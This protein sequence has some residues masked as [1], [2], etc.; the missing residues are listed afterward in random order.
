V[1]DN[2]DTSEELEKVIED[3][4]LLGAGSRVIVTTRNKYSLP[5]KL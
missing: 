2:V 4:D 3:C 5:S 1:L